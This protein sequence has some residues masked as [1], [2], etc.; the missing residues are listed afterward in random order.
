M[1]LGARG[2][3]GVILSRIF[4][5]IADALE[6]RET[7]DVKTMCHAFEEGVKKA[8]GAVSTPVEGTILTVYREAAEYVSKNRDRYTTFEELF[9]DFLAE[10]RRSLE[11]TP[12]LLKVL[13]EA[14]VVDSGGAG[15]YYIIEGMKKAL[16]SEELGTVTEESEGASET[17]ALVN[18]D[19]T[20]RLEEDGTVYG[21]CTEFL[22]QLMASKSHGTSLKIEQVEKWLKGIG[23]DSIVAF[24]DGDIVKVHV[25]TRNPGKVL[26]HFQK[27]GEYLK[28][29][30]ENMT[31]QNKNVHIRN[32]FP[33]VGEKADE[34]NRKAGADAVE[35]APVLTVEKP[36]SEYAFVAVAAGDGLSQVFRDGGADCVVDGGQSNNPSAQ[37]FIEAFKTV[38]ATTIVVLPNNKNIILT[39]NQAAELYTDSKVVVFPS[40]TVGEGYAALACADS[41]ST[42]SPDEMLKMMEESSAGVATGYVSKAVRDSATGSIKVTAGDYVGFEGGEILSDDKDIEKAAEGLCEKLSAGEHDLVIVLSGENRTEEDAEKLCNRL[43][44]K[45]PG[46][47]FAP[48]AGGQPIYDFIMIFE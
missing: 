31:L 43:S 22:L 37:T 10:T 25:H 36:V 39:A 20:D 35:K 16:D 27:Y 14:G 18:N 13:R 15:L 44:A 3:S 21:Y 46:T 1:L 23:G 5:G 29:K 38:R 24:R 33:S 34:E 12:Q 30:I 8:Y 28:L 42:V 32:N 4:A 26:E 9:D 2:N 19:S 45:F 7:S 41:S 40:R 11:R 47:E 48:A 17:Y 6:G